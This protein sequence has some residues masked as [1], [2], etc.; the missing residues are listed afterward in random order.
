MRVVD[1]QLRFEAQLIALSDIALVFWRHLAR[2]R[3]DPPVESESDS[4]IFK[5]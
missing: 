5:V 4:L 1:E 2:I 3:P